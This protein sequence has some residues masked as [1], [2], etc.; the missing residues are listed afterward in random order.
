[1]LGVNTVFGTASVHF[2]KLNGAADE[3]NA[4][5]K[6]RLEVNAVRRTHPRHVS[7]FWPFS[8]ECEILDRVLLIESA[9]RYI[10]DRGKSERDYRMISPLHLRRTLGVAVT[11]EYVDANVRDRSLPL[12]SP[13]PLQPYIDNFGIME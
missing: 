4:H 8:L 5:A 7:I 6:G 10:N 11:L 9:Q 1:M 12:I 3:R 2:I 13:T